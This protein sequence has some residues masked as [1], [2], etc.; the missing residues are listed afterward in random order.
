M[1]KTTSPTPTSAMKSRLIRLIQNQASDADKQAM[2]HSI[3]TGEAT[4]PQIASFMSA[5]AVRGETPSDIV[6]G[7][8]VLRTQALTIKAPATTLDIVGTGGDGTHSWNVSTAAALVIAGAGFP[9]AKHGNRA[10]SS[11]S[12]AADVLEAL[13]VKLD[14]DMA[15][16]QRAMDEAGIAFLMAP[17]HHSAMRHVAQVR[18]ELGFRSIFNLLGPLS[19]PALVKRIMIGVFD[20]T[21]LAPFAEALIAL[22]TTHALVVHGSDGMDEVTTTGETEA[23]LVRE[24]KT[25]PLTLHPSDIG[26]AVAD[27]QSLKGGTPAEN[28]AAISTLLA[29]NK[30]SQKSPQK[31]PMTDIT[32]LNAAAAMYGAGHVKDLRE[33]ADLA[34]DAIA[35]GKAQATL[36]KLIAIT[37]G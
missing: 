8:S 1:T 5:L 24:G 17:R 4:P 15:L 23:I 11:Q 9:V 20:K 22:G 10:V 29:G 35:S 34:R 12:G 31:S 6:A 16:V 37:N 7:A 26:L 2:F 36:A 27:P 18:G 14:A 19:N 33:G 21:W 25:Q 30:S 13:G 28:A 3:L 32:I